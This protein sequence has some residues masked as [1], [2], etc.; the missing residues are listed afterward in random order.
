MIFPERQDP[1]IVRQPPLLKHAKS[2]VTVCSNVYTRRQEISQPERDVAFRCRVRGPIALRDIVPPGVIDAVSGKHEIRK[3]SEADR[4][5]AFA[6]E[7]PDYSFALLPEQLL[8]LNADRCIDCKRSR[9]SVWYEAG[10]V[11]RKFVDRCMCHRP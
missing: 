8:E 1:E 6:G 11:R 2:N 3:V 10:K 9:V 5:A 7:L 4:A